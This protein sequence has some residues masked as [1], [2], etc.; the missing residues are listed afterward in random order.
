MA[1][2]TVERLH[3][4]GSPANVKCISIPDDGFLPN[5]AT[6]AGTRMKLNPIAKPIW[7]LK[8]ILYLTLDE[9]KLLFTLK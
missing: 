4:F 1:L 2:F 5:E 7:F 6:E 3:V 9:E 8:T